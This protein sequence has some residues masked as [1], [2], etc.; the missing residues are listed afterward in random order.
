MASVDDGERGEDGPEDAVAEVQIVFEGDADVRAPD[1]GRP[2]SGDGDV[3]SGPGTTHVVGNDRLATLVTTV[4]HSVTEL[5]E[6]RLNDAMAGLSGGVLSTVLPER[7]A[8]IIQAT[9]TP[10]DLVLALLADGIADASHGLALRLERTTEPII[11]AGVA[12]YRGRLRMN[13]PPT[14]RPVELR[15]YPTASGNLTVVELLP[16]RRWMPQT[17]RYLTAGVP[18][19]S[20]LTDTL[21]AAAQAVNPEQDI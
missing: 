4:G 1:L 17:K 19:V 6:Q 15:I 7:V 21:E 8:Q 5:R 12:T 16:R 9:Q 13:R 11:E 10:L 18:A 20:E 2:D 14:R 3:H